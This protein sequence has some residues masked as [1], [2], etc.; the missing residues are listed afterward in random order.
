MA[1]AYDGAEPMF[2]NDGRY[3]VADFLKRVVFDRGGKGGG[4][5]DAQVKG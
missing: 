5:A 4:S 3:V 2:S 1:Y